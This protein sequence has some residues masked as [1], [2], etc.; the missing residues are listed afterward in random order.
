[1][2]ATASRLHTANNQTTLRRL[3]TNLVK[4]EQLSYSGQALRVVGTDAKMVVLVINGGTVLTLSASYQQDPT[5][6]LDAMGILLSYVVI[7]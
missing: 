5:R 4:L 1:M 2:Y 6:G 3:G 7:G